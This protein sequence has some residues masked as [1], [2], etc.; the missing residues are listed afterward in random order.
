[1]SRR[2]PFLCMGRKRREEEPWWI[3]HVVARGVVRRALFRDDGDCQVYLVILRGVIA[4]FGWRIYAY[5]LMGNHVHLLVRTR[6]P[7]LGRG[8]QR[9]HSLYAQGFNEEHA[10]IGHLFQDR[11]GSSRIRTSERL[12]YV[13]RYIAENPVAAGFCDDA[14]SWPWSNHGAAAAGD[15]P[16]WLARRGVLVAVQRDLAAA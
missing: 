6:E 8:M 16:K 15:A 3:Y 4:V 2:C 1:M 11:Y 13:D 12:T 9:L 7:N 5:C 10:R 14:D